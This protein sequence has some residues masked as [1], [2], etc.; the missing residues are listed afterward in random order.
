MTRRGAHAGNR[1]RLLEN[2]LEGLLHRFGRAVLLRGQRQPRAQHTVRIESGRHALQRDRA[3]NQ[4]RRA[5]QQQQRQRQ[6]ADDQR[7]AQPIAD[8]GG[9][10]VAPGAAQA[11]LDVRSRRADGGREP[12]DEGAQERHADREQDDEAVEPRLLETRHSRGTHRHERADADLRQ[13]EPEQRGGQREHEALGQE[14]ADDPRPPGA[15]R[16]ANG[17]LARPR[18]AA[19]EQQVGEIAARDQQHEADRAEHHE[20]PRPIVSDDIVRHRDHQETQR[21][22]VL[23]IQRLDARDE[24]PEI[25]ER[26]VPGDTPSFSRPKTAR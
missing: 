2:R 5:R 13:R 19:R 3:L 26:L 1:A 24:A 16:R 25:A 21:L 15:E 12:E 22:R 14:L 7:R 23:R 18:R 8:A 10:G 4:Q 9:G 17:Q 11:G 6:L 20:E